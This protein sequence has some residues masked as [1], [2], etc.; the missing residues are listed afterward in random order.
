MPVD[1]VT[2]FESFWSRPDAEYIQRF[3]TKDV[4]G[5]WP[6]RTEPVRGPAAYAACI[7][8]IIDALPGVRLRIAEHAVTG[9]LIF[10][11]WIMH[12]DGPAGPFQLTGFDRV[13]GRRGKVAE[14]IIVFDTAAFEQL[15]G[16]PVPWQAAGQQS[17][18]K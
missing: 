16:K 9:N 8:G 12:A 10:I 13:R 5:H 3:L 6:G 18:T 2:G 15:S 11:R 4:V 14:N 17:R 7:G 1:L